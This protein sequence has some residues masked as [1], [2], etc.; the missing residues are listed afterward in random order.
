MSCMRSYDSPQTNRDTDKE[1]L[2]FFNQM[3]VRS[4]RRGPAGGRCSPGLA[5]ITHHF[6]SLVS[7]GDPTSGTIKHLM[8]EADSCLGKQPEPLYGD[9]QMFGLQIRLCWNINWA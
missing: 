2:D 4:F 1:K 8:K 3:V 7:T 5:N 6:T 9:Q